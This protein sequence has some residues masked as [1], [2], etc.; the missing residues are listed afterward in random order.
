MNG[1]GAGSDDR[2]ETEA[3]VEE[4]V[5]ELVRA[6]GDVRKREEAFAGLRRE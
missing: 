3:V 6:T 2:A 5:D 4:T 1:G